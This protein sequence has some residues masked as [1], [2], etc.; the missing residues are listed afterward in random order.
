MRISFLLV[1]VMAIAP[2]ATAFSGDVLQYHGNTARDGLYIDPA[3]SRAAASG[4][5]RDKSF[6]AP[7]QGP[8]YAQP[9]Y[10]N[11]GPGGK[12][13]IIV[14]TERNEVLALDASTGARLWT[15][16]LGNPVPRSDLPCGNIDLLGITGT[17]VIDANLRA[18]YVAAMTTPDRGRTKD[19]RIFALSI[20]DGSI[21]PGWPISVS[22]IRYGAFLFNSSV[23]NQRGALLLKNGVLYVPY[24]G[25]WGDCGDYHGWVIGVPVTNPKAA[26]AWATE[27]RGGG[28]WAPGGIASDGRSIFVA[29]GNTFGARS[30]MGGEAIIRLTSPVNF[31]GNA[32]DYFAPSN[33]RQ[34]D[35]EDADIGG[36]GPVL[37]DIPGVSPS[38]L[39]IAL[40]KNGVA[41]LLNQD[42]LGGIGK[43]NG[44]QGEGVQSN[45][46]AG[47]EIINAAAVYKTAAA[48]YAVFEARGNGVGCPGR[49]GNLV[50]L[51]IGISAPPSMAVA[52]CANN[53]GG[54]S[55]IVT[56]TDGNSDAIVWT[57]GAGSSNRLHAFDG[58]TGRLLFA[59]GGPDEQ[60]TRVQNF[61]TPIVA[62]GR[63]F[64]AA[65]DRIYAFTAARK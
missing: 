61:Q 15:K 28:I 47:G 21:R 1:L 17:P 2:F 36:S 30:W 27:A 52:W 16:T 23:Q 53:M 58:E 20:D 11:H 42:D 41:Y 48:T 24:G 63:I 54:G 29:T 50:A 3:I 45:K 32:T 44:I 22:G 4:M 64:V 62:N 57:V 43:G 12:A 18:I 19:H 56:S 13:A 35:S 7:V 59:G 38:K 31:S 9:L 34:L 25:H 49:S 10:V 6:D 33:W 65:N 60:M 8:I 55:P 51:R 5:Y 46:V 39:I 14:V 40:G 26:S 37:F